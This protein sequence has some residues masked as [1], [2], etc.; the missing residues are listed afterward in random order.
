MQIEQKG[1]PE[2]GSHCELSEDLGV[3]Q[4]LMD[5]LWSALGTSRGMLQTSIVRWVLPLKTQQSFSLEAS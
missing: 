4:K 1:A 5:R 2:K 3:L